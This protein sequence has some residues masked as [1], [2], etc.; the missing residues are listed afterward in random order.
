MRFFGDTMRNM[1]VSKVT[2]YDYYDDKV[3]ECYQL[4]RKSKTSK[5]APAGALAC[6]DMDTF[7]VLHCLREIAE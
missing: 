2:M 3:V 7:E 4:W 6:F 5:G 1:S